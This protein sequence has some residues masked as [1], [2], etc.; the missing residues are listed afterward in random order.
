ALA[1]RAREAQAEAIERSTAPRI[2]AGALPTTPAPVVLSMLD[3]QTAVIRA[4][5]RITA[6]VAQH[7]PRRTPGSRFRWP[8]RPRPSDVIDALDWLA[9]GDPAWMVSSTGVVV[10]RGAVAELRSVQV[11]NRVA[12]RLRA[13]AESARSAARITP[14]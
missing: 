10:R 2:G 7:V 1:A 5:R 4:L 3:A 11:A 8:A 12:E 14:D 13:T 9:G 6:D